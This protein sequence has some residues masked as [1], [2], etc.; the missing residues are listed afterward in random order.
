MSKIPKLMVNVNIKP[1]L[2]EIQRD[3][4]ISNISHMRIENIEQ[5]YERCNSAVEY[6]KICPFMVYND[7]PII[8][9]HSLKFANQP[10]ETII[11]RSFY[12]STGTSRNDI[13]IRDIWF[14]MSDL[15]FRQGSVFRGG[16]VTFYAIIGKMEDEILVQL[17][18]E[19]PFDMN[20]DYHTYYRF[21]NENNT[22]V[23]KI[24][25]NVITPEILSTLPDHS[26]DN[27]DVLLSMYEHYVCSEPIV[28]HI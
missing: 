6:I 4:T 14:P 3:I 12:K 10:T 13:T 9:V 17:M 24:L 26:A 11:N 20:A 19:L 8:Y 5:L 18:E 2:I 7:R 25:R 16:K 27:I 15:G 21:I 28:L 22:Y 1:N 23:S